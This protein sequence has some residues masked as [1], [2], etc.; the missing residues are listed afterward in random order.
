MPEGAAHPATM[1]AG[2]TVHARKSQTAAEPEELL[3][4]KHVGYR[5]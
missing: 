1:V 5:A 4:W 3:R 2:A